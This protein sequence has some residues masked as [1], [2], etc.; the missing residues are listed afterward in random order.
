MEK[1]YRTPFTNKVCDNILNYQL[2]NFYHPFTCCGQKMVVSNYGLLCPK[3]KRVQDWVHGFMAEF[4]PIKCK[5]CNLEMHPSF[6]KCFNC[7][8]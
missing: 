7:K 5:K 3:C 2:S 8:G 1:I 6:K 4:E